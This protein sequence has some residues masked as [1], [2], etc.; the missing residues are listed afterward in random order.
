MG[1]SAQLSYTTKI[2]SEFLSIWAKFPQNQQKFSAEQLTRFAQ[3]GTSTARIHPVCPKKYLLCSQTAP[4]SAQ[5]KTAMGR[6]SAKLA[7][8][9]LKLVAEIKMCVF[10]RFWSHEN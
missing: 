2:S 5:K 3:L 7:K 4:K 9:Q 8:M 10:D 1:E 6:I